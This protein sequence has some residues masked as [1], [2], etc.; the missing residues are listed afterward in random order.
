MERMQELQN[1]DGRSFKN[2]LG[3][4]DCTTFNITLFRSHRY[5]RKILITFATNHDISNY[6]YVSIEVLYISYIIL[7]YN[8]FQ[9]LLPYSFTFILQCVFLFIIIDAIFFL[10]Y[11]ISCSFHAR[12]NIFVINTFHI[13]M[14]VFQIFVH[15]QYSRIYRH[16]HTIIHFYFLLI[17]LF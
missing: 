14:F 17:H 9:K 5:F 12:Y 4:I 16:T 6:I 1:F 2:E 15:S 8:T 13:V 11:T 3:D 7:V 10:Y